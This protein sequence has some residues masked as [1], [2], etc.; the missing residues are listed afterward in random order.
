MALIIPASQGLFVH[1][2]LMM[3]GF[4]DTNNYGVRRP[5]LEWI[6]G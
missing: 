2:G 3:F 4:H 1:I 6:L 5:H